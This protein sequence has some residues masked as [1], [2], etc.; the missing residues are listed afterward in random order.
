MYDFKT[1]PK[2]RATP[3]P[4]P[5]PTPAAVADPADPVDPV[6]GG[7][8]ACRSCID[9]DGLGGCYLYHVPTKCGKPTISPDDVLYCR[10]FAVR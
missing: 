8:R 4:T 10:D 1:L 9:P 2:P 7:C 3:K 5:T 6:F